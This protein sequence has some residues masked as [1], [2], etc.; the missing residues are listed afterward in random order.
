MIW[1]VLVGFIVLLSA[2][3]ALS[4]HV[5]ERRTWRKTAGCFAVGVPFY[6][7]CIVIMAI[8]KPI[9]WTYRLIKWVHR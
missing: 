2:H 4:L 9:V 5:E 1:L 8:G 3:N 6:I 7:L